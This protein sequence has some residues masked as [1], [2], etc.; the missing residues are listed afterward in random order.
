[1]VMVIVIVIIIVIVIL[2]A[3]VIEIFSIAKNDPSHTPSFER[4]QHLPVLSWRQQLR[5]PVV[6]RVTYSAR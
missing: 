2:I 3:D 6:T 4:Q 1:M 5:Q